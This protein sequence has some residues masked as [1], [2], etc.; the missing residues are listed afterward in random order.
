M[1]FQSRLTDTF[2]SLK[3]RK[4]ITL[5]I[6]AALLIGY[7]FSLPRPLFDVPYCTLVSDRNGELLGARIASDGQ[8]RFP[9]TDSVPDKYETCL[10]QFEDRHF[11]HHPGVDPLS[12]GRALVQNVKA[13]RIVSGGSTITMQTVRL[14]RHNRRTYFEKLI[15]IIL[16]TRLE[17][18]YSKNR[19]LALYVSH[20]PMGGNVVGID[21]AAWRYF[22]PKI[23]RASCRERV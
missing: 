1:I 15:E 20:A 3:R 13:G 10:I 16:A 7:I 9:P 5:V 6:L 18:S 14:M 19:I 23:G 12:L 4:K 21:A 22:L 2:L 8:W 17:C 11:R